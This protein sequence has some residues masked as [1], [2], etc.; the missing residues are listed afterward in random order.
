MNILFFQSLNIMDNMLKLMEKY[1][2]SLEEQVQERTQQL[3][4]E[5][6]KTDMLLYSML[7]Q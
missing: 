6:K 1:A 4:D 7:P 3:E 2:G 5:K